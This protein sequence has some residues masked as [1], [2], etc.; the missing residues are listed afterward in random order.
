MMTR[1]L[2]DAFEQASQLPEAEQNALAEWLLQ[3][4]ES[5]ERWDRLF[6]KSA[7]KLETLAAEALAEH[8][9]GRTHPLTETDF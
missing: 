3:E 7:D 4:L 8:R 2:S 1:L 5:E 9:A 6:E